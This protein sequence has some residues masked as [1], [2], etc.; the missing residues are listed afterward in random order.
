VEVPDTPGPGTYVKIDHSSIS[1]T[2]K[3]KKESTSAFGFGVGFAS[4][5]NRFVQSALSNA[6]VKNPSPMIELV[7]ARACSSP[8]PGQYAPEQR[9]QEFGGKVF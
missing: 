9:G 5:T 7:Y 8:G 3:T 1:N 4:K 2:S 6:A